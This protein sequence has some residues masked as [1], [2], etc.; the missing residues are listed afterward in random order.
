[1][2]DSDLL[3]LKHDV[4]RH[5]EAVTEDAKEI[6]ELKADVR[7]LFSLIKLLSVFVRRETSGKAGD[8]ASTEFNKRLQ[9]ILQKHGIALD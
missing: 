8:E 1:M 5:E 2:D 7:E 3:N 6:G 9:A 4:E